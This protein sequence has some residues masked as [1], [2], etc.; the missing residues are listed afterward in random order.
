M[1]AQSKIQ[2]GFKQH[3]LEHTIQRIMADSDCWKRRWELALFVL[4]LTLSFC[5]MFLF[6]IQPH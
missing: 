3:H 5:V 4:S 6:A 1:I 2:N